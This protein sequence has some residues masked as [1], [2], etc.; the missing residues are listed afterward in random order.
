M[1]G[2]AVVKAEGQPCYSDLM[3]QTLEAMGG[4][5][6]NLLVNDEGSFSTCVPVGYKEVLPCVHPEFPPKLNS[7][8]LDDSVYNEMA[9]N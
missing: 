5:D 1:P 4:P 6:A 3:A 9:V 2:S 8:K 7:S